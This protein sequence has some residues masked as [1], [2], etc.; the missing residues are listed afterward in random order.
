MAPDRVSGMFAAGRTSLVHSRPKC[1]RCPQLYKCGLRRTDRCRFVA[2]EIVRRCFHIAYCSL[3]FPNCR[4]DAR[5]SDGLRPHGLCGRRCRKPSQNDGKCSRELSHCSLRDPPAPRR[6]TPA[7][8][9]SIVNKLTFG[10]RAPITRCW[11][12][13]PTRRKSSCCRHTDTTLMWLCMNVNLIRVGYQRQ[14]P[15]SR[16]A[17]ARLPPAARVG[18]GFSTAFP[19]LDA[20]LQLPNSSVAAAYVRSTATTRRVTSPFLRHLVSGRWYCA[21]SAPGTSWRRP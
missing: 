15:T 17:Q 21:P 14:S 7:R 1:K 18:S 12:S 2:V 19:D 4:C 6:H 9:V 3:H 20:L 10:V 16:S 11:H 8:C 5:M 13:T